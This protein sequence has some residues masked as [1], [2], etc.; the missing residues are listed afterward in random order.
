MYYIVKKVNQFK[1]YWNINEGRWEG[2]I[3]N[4]SLLTRELAERIVDVRRFRLFAEI[5]HVKKL[6]KLVNQ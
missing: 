4:G 6:R 2:L 3:D 1:Y 5:I